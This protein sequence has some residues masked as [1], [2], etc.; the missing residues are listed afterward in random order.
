MDT[1]ARFATLA[2]HAGQRPDPATGSLSTPI[3]QTSTFVFPSAEEGARRFAGEAAGYIY[4]R[5]GNPTQSVLEE[6]LAILEGGEAA[7]AFGSG[8][9]AISGVIMAA[10]SAGDHILYGEPIYGST[11]ALLHHVLP[12]F[13]VSATGVDGSD[14]EQVAAAIRPNTRLLLF[15]TPANPT[16]KLVDIAAVSRVAHDQGVLVVCDNTFASPALQQPLTLGADVV[17]H[18]CTKYIGGHGDVIAGAVVGSKEFIEHLRMTSL[19]DLGGVISPFDAWLLLRGLK[20]LDVRMERHS[21]NAQRVAEFLAGH[22]LVERVYYPGLPDHPQYELARRQMRAPGG[23]ISFEIRGG[24]DAGRLLMNSVRLCHLA[25]SLGDVD[26]LIQHPASMT[27]SMVPPEER[28]AAGI[29]DGLI[30]LSV[31]IE[32][33]EDIIADLAQGLD[34]VATEL[35]LAAGKGSPDGEHGR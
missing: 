31:G 17:V 16:M 28:L 7:L 6:K 29:T 34:R 13:G 21:R 20:T 35:T 24:V 14:P 1:R 3:Y 11:H 4:T 12:R 25:V 32:D 15:E 8:M 2:V 9:A 5:L 26:T 22:P 33:P 27:H 18:S 30:R 19:K 23:M 10:V